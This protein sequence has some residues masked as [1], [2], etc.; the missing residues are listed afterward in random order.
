MRGLSREAG[1]LLARLVAE[2][3]WALMHHDRVRAA[4]LARHPTAV[5]EVWGVCAALEEGLAFDFVDRPGAPMPAGLATELASILMQRVFMAP[6]LA[7]F[8]VETL[9]RAFDRAFDPGREA[10]W[11]PP[12]ESLPEPTPLVPHHPVLRGEPRGDEVGGY[13]MARIEPGTFEVG[14]PDLPVHAESLLARHRVALPSPRREVT[15]T[16]P[17][18]VGRVPVTHA[19]W[20]AIAGEPTPDPT[21][22]FDGHPADGVDFF[23]AAA[24]CNAASRLAGL[25][26]A[27]ALDGRSVRWP[28]PAAPGYRLPTEAEW[29][30]AARGGVRTRYASGERLTTG[31]ANFDGHLEGGRFYASSTPVGSFEANALGLHDVHGNVWEWCWDFAAGADPGP[32]LDPRGPEDGSYRLVR[33][34]AWTCW[35]SW[36]CAAGLRVGFRPDMSGFDCGLRLVRTLPGQA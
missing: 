6:S 30:V 25:P 28:D 18:L 16:R 19:L 14:D 20:E 4:V 13:A 35:R 8:S 15:L 23:A 7:A 1:E 5:W 9:A 29:E 12:E 31:D 11:P 26:E 21:F 10:C 34:G 32:A 22:R 3:P 33:G 17:F 24:F 36:Q 27:Y 2:E